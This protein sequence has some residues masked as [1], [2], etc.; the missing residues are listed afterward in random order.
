MSCKAS[1]SITYSLLVMKQ[2]KKHDD[3]ME[4]VIKKLVSQKLK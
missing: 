2:N 3:E 1:L 4:E